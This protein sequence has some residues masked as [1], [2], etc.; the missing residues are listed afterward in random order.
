MSA[1]FIRIFRNRLQQGVI[2]NTS[3]AQRLTTFPANRSVLFYKHYTAANG[4]H[5]GPAEPG[6]LQITPEAVTAGKSLA[7]VI[8]GWAVFKLF[9]FD[10]VV[11]HNLKVS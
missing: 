5:R 8:R 7:E 4:H 3:E 2:R 11:D 10:V 9:D 6:P 1:L